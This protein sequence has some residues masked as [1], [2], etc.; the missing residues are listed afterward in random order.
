M[1]MEWLTPALL[2]AAIG[3]IGKLIHEYTKVMVKLR[4]LELRIAQTEIKD[5]RIENKID[6]LDEHL[7]EIRRELAEK[8]D[9]D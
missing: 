2:L 1:S 8:Q 7:V 6:K 5:T 4:E 9:R 3:M